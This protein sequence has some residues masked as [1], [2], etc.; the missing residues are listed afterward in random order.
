MASELSLSFNQG[1]ASK[2]DGHFLL[3]DLVWL[4]EI[5]FTSWI[6]NSVACPNHILV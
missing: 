6:F 4:K 5:F 3:G 1:A 2:N